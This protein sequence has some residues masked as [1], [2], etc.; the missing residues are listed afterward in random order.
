MGEARWAGDNEYT[1]HPAVRR[2]RLAL[3]RAA[4][5]TPEKYLPYIMRMSNSIRV[6]GSKERPVMK[7]IESPYM[8]V[9]GLM[10]WFY[11]DMRKDGHAYTIEP[12]IVEF[13]NHVVVKTT[14]TVYATDPPTVVSDMA[15]VNFGG[16]N[17]ERTHP[18]ETATTSALGRALSRLGYGTFGGNGMATADEMEEVARRTEA[19][20]DEDASASE[21]A[22]PTAP[23][24]KSATEKQ[25]ALIRK[26][27]GD[28]GLSGRQVTEELAKVDT[29]TQ[30]SEVIDRLHALKSAQG[31]PKQRDRSAKIDATT[32]LL[33]Y[34]EGHTLMARLSELMLADDVLLKDLTPD[35]AS[36][37]HETLRAE[38]A[39][40]FAQEGADNEQDTM[41]GGMRDFLDPVQGERVPG[42]EG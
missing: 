19:L 1:D 10:L 27:C 5:N 31:A 36:E 20:D 38:V 13:G 41:W 32:K 17:A 15:S 21:P 29:V 40:A 24:S 39:E 6:G 8:T 9:E 26:L 7:V 12:H 30:A 11:D 42:E 18:I 16:A 4:D 14:I 34:A 22:A 25:I 3:K 37:L 28:L 23:A 35:K 33:A 2:A